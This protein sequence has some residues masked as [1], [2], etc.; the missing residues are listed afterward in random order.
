[1]RRSLKTVHGLV[2]AL[3]P[4]FPSSAAR[5]GIPPAAKTA[6]QGSPKEPLG[7]K[8]DGTE[9]PQGVPAPAE[10]TFGRPVLGE[11]WKL[12]GLPVMMLNGLPEE[13]STNGATVP[14]LKNLLAKLSPESS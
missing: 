11:N 9:E 6:K 12:S 10:T 1:M 13:T 8:R 2:P 4:K 7:E 14:L 5:E 3:R